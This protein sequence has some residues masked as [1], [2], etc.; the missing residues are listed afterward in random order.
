MIHVP[1][2]AGRNSRSVAVPSIAFH[3]SLN[4]LVGKNTILV[5]Y[6][7]AVGWMLREIGKRDI[8]AEENFLGKHY[9]VMPSTMLRYAIEKFSEKRRKKYLKGKI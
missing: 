4:C 1:V 2:E 9:K 5:L 3:K 7:K 8:A 6:L